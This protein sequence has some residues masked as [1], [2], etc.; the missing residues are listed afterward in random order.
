[1]FGAFFIGRCT[2]PQWEQWLALEQKSP[3]NADEISLIYQFGEQRKA[4][5]VRTEQR[6]TGK[7]MFYRFCR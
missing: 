2:E 4:R 6:E 5:A 1:M 7:A 3:F